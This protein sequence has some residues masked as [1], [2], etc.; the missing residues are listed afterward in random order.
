METVMRTRF[1]SVVAS[2]LLVPAAAAAQDQTQAAPVSD[3][4]YINQIDFGIRGTAYG[5]GS[6]QARFQRYRDVRSG[7]TV[8]YLHIIKE[9]NRYSAVLRGEHLGFGDQRITGTY[10][11]FGTLKASF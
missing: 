7:P 11:N 4:P 2:V 5:E 6:D 9:T 1:L 8:D 3:I 10:H